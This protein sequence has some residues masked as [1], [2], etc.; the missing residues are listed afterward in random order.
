[1][2]DPTRGTP[3]VAPPKVPSGK[4][5][6]QTPPELEPG[7]G[8]S[9]LLSSML[10]MLGSV[11]AIVMV[12]MNN[13]GPTGLLTGGMFLMSS[14]G[15]VAVNGWR[16]RSQRVAGILAARREYLMYLT[17]LRQ[18]V[19]VAAKQQRKSA[20]WVD[21]DPASLVYVAE[22][23]SRV[24][25]RS[26]DDSDFMSVRIGLSSQP[27]CLTL[28][29]P[30]LPPLAQL[31]PVAAS[32]AHR[33]MVT[34][35]HQHDLPRSA[36]LT[37][38]SRVEIVGPHEP[39][40][41]SL[42]RA[43]V[44]QAATLHS[45]EHL[46]IAIIAGENSIAEWEWAKWLP[47]THSQHTTDG[48]G[49]ARMI[50]PVLSEIVD[51]LPKDIS[52]RPRFGRGKRSQLTPHLLIVVD[53]GHVPFGNPVVTEDGVQGV[54][55]IELPTRWQEVEDPLRL[56]LTVEQHPPLDEAGRPPMNVIAVGE[57]REEIRADQ[58]TVEEAEA[59]ARR[60]MPMFNGT[61]TEVGESRA[62]TSAELVDLLGIGDVRDLDFDVVWKPRLQRDRLRVPIGLTT[63]G[64]PI[65]LDIKESAQQGMGPHGLII[66]ATG[67]G[68][69]EVLRTLVLAL[70][71]TH[72][73][74]QLNFVLVDFKGGATFAGMAGMPHVSAIITN[75][76]EELTLVDRMQDALQGEMVRRQELLRSAGNFANVS[77]YEKA[78]MNGRTDLDPLPALL[79]VADEFSELLEAKPE[80]VETFVNI[81]RLGRSL[82][83]HLLLSSQRLEEGKLKG[84]DSHLSYRIGL[85][86]F[87]AA[88]SRAVLGVADAYTLPPMPGVGYLKPDTTTMIQFRASYVSGPPQSRRRRSVGPGVVSSAELEIE[89]FTAAPVAQRIDA[90][91]LA[92][93]EPESTPEPEEDGSTFEL[94]VE[95][96][97]GR[98]PSAH[99][100]W[101][102]P[103]VVPATMDQLMP[104]LT[105]DPELGLVSRTWRDAGE[106]VV[107][108]GTVDRP[109]EQRRENLTI[110]LGGAAGHM[111]IVGGPRTGKSTLARTVMVA[112][113]LTHTPVEVQFY[114]LDFGGGTFSPLASY[115]HVSGVAS[116][117]EPEV[118]RRLLAEVT[119]IVNNRE[120]YFRN[121]GI[122]SIETYRQ[123]RESGRADDGYGDIFLIVDG[124]ATV[125]TEFESLEPLVLNL[126]SR[127]LTFGV[128]V[129]LTAARW[130]DVRANIKDL[131]GTRLELRLGDPTDSE[132]DRKSAFNVPLEAP[133]RG[134]TATAH[135]MLTALPRIDGDGDHT[136]LASGVEHLMATVQ[137]AWHGPVGPKLR[138]L[139]EMISMDEIRALAPPEQRTIWL[140][141]DE[142]NLAPIGI[143]PLVEPHLYLY[144]DSGSGKSSMLRSYA[145]EIRRLYT[146]QEA[147]I[148]VVD[149]RRAL[150]GEIPDD[151]LG[152]YLTTHEAALSGMNELSSFFRSRLPGTDV[153]P[154][155]LRSRSWWTGAEG[156]ILVDDYDLVST[157]QGNPLQAIVPLLAQAADVG[158][159][160]IMTRRSGGASRASYD[161]MIQ[162]M[163]DLGVTGILLSGNPEEG[164]L[165]GK[166]K[167]V[168]SV[169]GRAQIVNRAHG[170]RGAHLG[171]VTPT[172]G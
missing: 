149:F 99:Q 54:S 96:M 5:S 154:E 66:G 47:H 131:M 43:M 9:T 80:F 170:M 153:T 16:Q 31:D 67:S 133:G 55:V 120:Q 160:V 150:L 45:P 12:S 110:S 165:I 125:R 18:T 15:F 7:D 1:M 30:D 119:G 33:F 155:Q 88:E 60:L 29:S 126:A 95:R 162:G 75:L 19:R 49:P 72:S 164:Q 117:N 52:E 73:P 169:P 34:H 94:A 53:G 163:T 70:A 136:S 84:L 69:S 158:M 74:E 161:P 28:E 138:L 87:S 167:A 148:F 100:V 103:L 51:L 78:R 79:I 130:M 144:G 24:W 71:L 86:T 82:Q 114:V 156:F 4:L 56:R 105:I 124:W 140:G 50:A 89:P 115:P 8:I 42:A 118:V 11:G 61:R 132:L 35:Q 147:K 122:D 129:V 17:E 159:H 151:Y 134:I 108:L 142:A 121:N 128:H 57:T 77:D 123:W 13:S 157:S 40:L 152:A 139:P 101:L 172:H 112:L 46:Q 41:R 68:K 6:I 83:V 102:P 32:A 65:S 107:P 63:E 2:S 145:S 104:D 38:F 25:E 146:P 92:P 85:R 116:R 143:D 39:Y 10:P 135:Q 166:L 76:G 81:G 48:V 109:L 59:A 168:Q 23:R 14:L 90:R 111:A 113:S 93:V 20:Y 27:L 44:I 36:D 26:S 171:Y 64:I 106:L 91:E 21:P 3:R 62:A 98:G 58:I 22:E 141:I 137:D 127:G 97:R 37:N